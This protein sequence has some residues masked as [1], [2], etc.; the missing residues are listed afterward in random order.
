MGEQERGGSARS[1][2]RWGREVE[3]RGGAMNQSGEECALLNNI[4]IQPW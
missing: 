1:E 3:K 4:L 2:R